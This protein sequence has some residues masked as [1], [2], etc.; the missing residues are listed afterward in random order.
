[1]F[2]EEEKTIKLTGLKKGVNVE[3]FVKS[4]SEDVN[5]NFKNENNELI[6]SFNF[7]AKSKSLSL[8]RDDILEI[9]FPTVLEILLDVY[10][11]VKKK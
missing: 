9:D 1:M 11:H 10:K 5:G 3:F 4:N 8:H 6:G 7:L 2:T